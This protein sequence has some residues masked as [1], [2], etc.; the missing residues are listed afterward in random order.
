MNVYLIIILLILVSYYLKKNN[1]KCEK[2]TEDKIKLDKIKSKYL[3]EVIDGYVKNNTEHY[4][5]SNKKL[6]YM[7]N[8]SLNDDE[9]KRKNN[10]NKYSKSKSNKSMNIKNII[11]ICIILIFLYFINYGKN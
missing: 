2:F 1:K 10:N 11:I 3:G 9:I 8:T 5:D 7:L 4:D 6:I